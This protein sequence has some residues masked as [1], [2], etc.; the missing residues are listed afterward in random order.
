[1][2]LRAAALLAL[3]TLSCREEV[4]APAPADSG[5]PELSLLTSLPVAFAEGFSLDAPAHPLMQRLEKD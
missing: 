2:T 4:P 3:L 1:M 5:K